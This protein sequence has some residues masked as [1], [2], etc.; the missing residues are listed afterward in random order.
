MKL[1]SVTVTAAGKKA[2]AKLAPGA[3]PQLHV[4]GSIVILNPG[5]RR[6]PLSRRVELNWESA[7]L[8]AV[9]RQLEKYKDR[10]FTY[11]T[12]WTYGR[13]DKN[14]PDTSSIFVASYTTGVG[15]GKSK[16]FKGKTA[17]GKFVKYL[18]AE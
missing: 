8:S 10:G 7:P 2:E 6:G 17:L 13:N 9:K 14:F 1:V 15:P 4:S 16:Y 5:A 18:F 3:T 11:G 12:D